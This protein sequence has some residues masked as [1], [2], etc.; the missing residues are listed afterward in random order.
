ML[1]WVC[2]STFRRRPRFG[3]SRVT[4]EPSISFRSAEKDVRMDSTISST[5]RR[6]A[7]RPKRR[8]SHAC[9]SA[10][11]SRNDC[12][13]N[14]TRTKIMTKIS[15]REHASLFGPTTGDRIRL[16]DTDLYIEIENDLRG[17]GDE[18][19][20]GGGKSIR[21]GMG[22]DNALTS[23]NGAPDLVITNV[24]IIDAMLGVVKADVGIKDGLICGIG[25]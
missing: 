1:R 21:E 6:K 2:T 5:A 9:A 3:S 15:R 8:L 18:I 14:I 7:A 17:F 24:T 12:A 22:F 4:N 13:A 25:R 11:S 10:A 20:F 16:G 19:V 23:R